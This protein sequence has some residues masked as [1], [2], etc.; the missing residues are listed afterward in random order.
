M[1][2]S[3]VRIPVI[4]TVG[5]SI[6]IDP[7]ATVGAT[8]GTDLHLPD[9]TVPTLAQLQTLFGGTTQQSQTPG[10]SPTLWSLINE[11]PSDALSVLGNPTNA[12]ARPVAIVAS[13]DKAV[14]HRS[15]TAIS[16]SP[17]DH[18]YISDFDEEAQDAVGGILANTSSITL[19]Y[20]D[21][22]PSISA[23]IVDEYVQD[24]VGAMLVDS[25]SIDF[26]YNDVA[27]TFTAS[28]I[29]ANPTASIGLT[30][31]NGTAATP[32]RS[33]AAPA[34]D[35]SIAPTWTAQHDFQQS[36]VGTAITTAVR[37]INP[38]AAANGAQQN[39]PAFV[40]RGSGWK[41]GAGGAS[42]TQDWAAY[43]VPV[44]G[45]AASSSTLH[46][47]NS[48]AGGA[49]TDVLTLTSGGSLSGSAL[50]WNGAVIGTTVGGTGLSSYAIGD[51]LYG[52][53]T[54][55]LSKLA[56]NTTNVPNVLV[57]TGSGGIATAP[58]WIGLD[59]SLVPADTLE[60]TL[61]GPWTP[62]IGINV[63]NGSADSACEFPTL[64]NNDGAVF[65]VKNG[66]SFNLTV[67]RSGSDQLYITSAVNSFVLSPGQG[68]II[69][70]SHS[71]WYVI[72]LS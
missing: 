7:K 48:R 4:G 49:Y 17:I 52:S 14:L 55:V 50:T 19:T 47:G 11:M 44:Q 23:A 26:S 24:V 67:Q 59:T 32:M 51:I 57:S 54:N 58:A 36:S 16:F 60:T 34:L 40:L 70:G 1:P 65:Y 64:A 45:A 10:L 29:N 28:T 6:S 39:S 42:Q 35:Q 72:C 27:G 61:V 15:G 2:N 21:S 33:D 68:A 9:G 71:F 8:I 56:G 5:K 41:T 18:T 38:T 13:A 69:V 46:I 20:N 63:Y 3:R 37:L 30:A 43:M 22:T 62:T 12:V 25:T 66:S 31:I 53:A